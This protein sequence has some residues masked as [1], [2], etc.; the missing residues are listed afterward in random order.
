MNKK[1]TYGSGRGRGSSSGR[2]FS[3][4]PFSFSDTST[5]FSDDDGSF[6]SG[7]GSGGSSSLGGESYDFDD[8][9]S[10]RGSSSG[11]SSF[12]DKYG[13]SYTGGSSSFDSK[14]GSS[15]LGGSSS[16]DSKYG[17]SYTGGSSS[18]DSKYGS[19]SVGG[20]SSFDS[21]YGSSSVGGSSS[22]DSKYGSSSVGGTSSSGSGGSSQSI[23]T[24]PIGNNK[25]NAPD[26]RYDSDYARNPDANPT[27][28]SFQGGMTSV[29]VRTAPKKSVI[30]FLTV[31]FIFGV[32]IFIIF[33]SCDKRKTI[34][35][36]LNTGTGRWFTA[37]I[38]TDL[39]NTE[40]LLDCDVFASD[41]STLVYDLRYDV[42][43]IS[44][45][46]KAELDRSFDTKYTAIQIEIHEAMEDYNLK[47]FSIDYKIRNR[48]Y[49][50]LAEYI[51]D[52]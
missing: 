43:N 17:S 5:E 3:D 38:K 12:A 19:S 9:I 27:S 26:K 31:V 49:A 42:G 13:S 45:V 1:Y 4:D 24:T 32:S 48:D 25:T 22:F 23:W 15:S 2:D 46:D 50:V 35:D 16:F 51:I 7:V 40:G 29:S 52:P 20:S 34:Q 6:V 28:N 39:K 8:D 41:S 21:K 47:E 44:S 11:G 33:G 37:Q 36:F 18:F 10:T 30:I 14:Y